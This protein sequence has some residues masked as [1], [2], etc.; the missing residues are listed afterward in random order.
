MSGQT[1]LRVAMIGGSFMAKVHSSAYA[2]LPAFSDHTCRVRRQV[3][4][5]ASDELAER[6]ASTLGF[7]EWS[8]DWRSVVSRDDIDAIDIVAPNDLH[9]PIVLAA[10]A[11]GKHVLCEKPLA[12][13]LAEARE[14]AEAVDEAGVANVVC[15]NYRHTPAIALA[16][17]LI[18]EGRLGELRHFRGHYLQDWAIDPGLP[19]SWRFSRAV[20][21]SGAA[22]DI[23][24][25][26]I[27]YALHLMGPVERVYALDRTFVPSRPDGTDL[28]D[29]DVDDAVLS[30][31]EFPG[32]AVGTLEATRFATGRKNSL[33][34]EINGSKGALRF[35]WDERDWLY[36]Y[37]ACD[38]A[39]ERGFRAI[40][41]GPESPL[42]EAFWPIA[43]IGFG[44]LEAAVIQAREFVRAAHGEPFNAPTFAHGVA[45]ESVLDALLRSAA[46]RDWETV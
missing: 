34:F 5:E 12:C 18:E 29:V 32:G 19:F 25:H 40:Q 37:D 9:H 10:A 20:S 16:K 22:G 46:E 15:F 38:D 3:L 33:G 45:V 30:L 26:L 14:M 21:G 11:E 28:S 17:T 23:A 36:F 27:D 2:M 13:N 1:E 35:S 24:S 42:G 4:V 6:A 7:D 39:R 8:S 31:V 43:G 44:F 41:C